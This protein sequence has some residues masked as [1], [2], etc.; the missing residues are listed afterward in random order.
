MRALWSAATADE[1]HH[2]HRVLTGELRQGANEGVVADA[3]A[4]A[5]G[6]PIADRSSSGDAARRSRQGSAARSHRRSRST[7]G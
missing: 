4:K 2:L 3:V 6:Q 7:S 1:Q 5:S